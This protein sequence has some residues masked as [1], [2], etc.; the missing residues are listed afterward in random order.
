VVE[1]CDA[2]EGVVE[3]I[4]RGVCEV[5]SWTDWDPP[6]PVVSA[7]MP[8][9]K[10]YIGATDVEGPFHF[11]PDDYSTPSQTGIALIRRGN[12]PFRGEL[13]LPGGYIMR[14]ETPRESLCGEVLQETGIKGEVECFL[15]PCNP[16]PGRLNQVILHGLV[17]PVDGKLAAGDDAQEVM[18]VGASELPK[19]CFSSHQ[20]TAGDYTDG[21]NGFITGKRQYP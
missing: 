10:R 8:F 5:C 7:L 1:R 20:K 4:R 14:G 16:L 2:A 13:A 11:N 19:L 17:R 3:E 12:D 9:P 6:V 21:K 18:I 15:H